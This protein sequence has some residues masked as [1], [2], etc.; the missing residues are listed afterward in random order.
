MQLI[1][2]LVKSFPDLLDKI[3]GFVTDMVNGF[4]SGVSDFAEIG[5]AII[6][7]IWSG[8]SAG[9]EWLKSKVKEVAGSLFGAAKEELE[10][11]SPSRKFKWLAEMCV[12]GW[13][14]G[15]EELM[16]TDSMTKNVRASFSAM[17]ANATG[18]NAGGAGAVCGGFQQIV[19]INQ[20]VRTPDE[21]ARAMRLESKY[22]LVRGDVVYE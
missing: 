3:P 12:A 9:W 5:Q 4:L 18:G 16:S 2:G 20:P 6:D 8:I 21:M 19:N 22:G 15:A 1:A 14:E 11:N 17:K 10:V 7:G 13:D